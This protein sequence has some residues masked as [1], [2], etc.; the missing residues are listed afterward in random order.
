MK[1]LSFKMKGV[2]SLIRPSEI[3]DGRNKIYKFV[4]DGEIQQGN[5]KTS[6]NPAGIL[7]IK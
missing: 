1:A 7:A 4:Q 5:G 2:G 6:E 3:G